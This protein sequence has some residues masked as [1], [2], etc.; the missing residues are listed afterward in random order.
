MLPGPGGLLARDGVADDAGTVGS[1]RRRT[2]AKPPS[3]QPR[4]ED[5]HPR[6]KKADLAADQIQLGLLR[7]VERVNSP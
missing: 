6:L 3:P 5:P 7:G 1:A 4:I 2:A